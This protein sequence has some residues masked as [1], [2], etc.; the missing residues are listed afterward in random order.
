MIIHMYATGVAM[1]NGKPTQKAG[2]GV[3]LEAVDSVGRKVSRTIS[4]PVGNCTTPC[5][6]INAARIALA[7]VVKKY[8]KEAI[9]TL[10]VSPYVA[11]LFEMEGENFKTN[12]KKNAE[13][14]AELR[15]W[16]GYF[17]KLK[18]KASSRDDL[19]IPLDLAKQCA[20]TQNKSDTGTQ[21]I[22]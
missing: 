11:K 18:V 5:A 4:Y 9:V 20:E 8:R 6:E 17:E 14:V 1:N 21:T 12:P 10:H 2:T 19:M 15:R 3:I 22:A 7:S 16:S 13:Q